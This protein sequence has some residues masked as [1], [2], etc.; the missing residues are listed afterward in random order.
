MEVGAREVE[1]LEKTVVF[2]YGEVIYDLSF[3]QDTKLT[4][5]LVPASKI[6]L[7]KMEW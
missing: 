1:E 4:Q 3:Y 5:L 6:N 2:G 7:Q